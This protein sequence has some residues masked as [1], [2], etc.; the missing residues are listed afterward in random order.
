MSDVTIAEEMLYEDIA[1]DPGAYITQQMTK[2]MAG[3]PIDE[4]AMMM[5]CMLL[6]SGTLL[7]KGV[8]MDTIEYMMTER[9]YEWSIT[10]NTDG[11]LNVK[12]VFLDEDGN[13]MDEGDDDD[14]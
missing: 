1:Q 11:E 3:K 5:A 8:P 2:K 14:E 9:D 13:P 7:A 12:Q 6:M 10:F 4:D